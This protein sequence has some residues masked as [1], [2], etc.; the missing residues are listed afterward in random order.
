MIQSW[1][2]K[3]LDTMNVFWF[4]NC[5]AL[6][7]SSFSFKK[8]EKLAI[9]ARCNPP[10]G[11]GYTRAASQDAS[12]AINAGLKGAFK[13]D[14]LPSRLHRGHQSYIYFFGQQLRIQVKSTLGTLQQKEC[15]LVQ[16][17]VP[18]SRCVA[19]AHS[20][21]CSQKPKGTHWLRDLQQKQTI[22]LGI[23]RWITAQADPGSTHQ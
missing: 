8:H 11:M 16:P 13:R 18:C 4:C 14:G 10:E 22:P 20:Q 7:K 23:G 9:Q 5:F 12:F 1:C 3:Y 15:L 19:T 6:P 21:K 17:Q 2:L